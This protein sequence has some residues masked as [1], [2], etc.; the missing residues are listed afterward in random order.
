MKRHSSQLG[1]WLFAALVLITG[2]NKKKAAIVPP[3]A[4]APTVS[5]APPATSP[6]AEPATATPPVVIIPPS[7]QTNTNAGATKPKPKSRPR[8]THA[9][10]NP[11]AGTSPAAGTTAAKETGGAPPATSAPT[12]TANATPPP[13]NTPPK[14][15][16]R[17]GG[18]ADPAP[19]V[20]LPGMDQNEAAQQ[21]HAT[22]Q[23]LQSTDDNLKGITRPLNDDERAMVE[24]IR[25]YMA[26]SRAA[27]TDG[28][29]LR[30]NNLATKAHLLADALMKR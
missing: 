3:N 10:R 26:Q 18:T 6:A 21:R 7:N 8:P 15:T 20:I 11:P 28:D 17:E 16:V 9:R 2:C 13:V 1:I 30:A 19:G 5:T 14:T 24:Q 23:L 27:T 4:T 29:L 12:T 25:N 22:E